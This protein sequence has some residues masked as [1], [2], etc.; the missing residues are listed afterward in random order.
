MAVCLSPE[1]I[2]TRSACGEA[3]WI[4]EKAVAKSEL[5]GSAVIYMAT[6]FFV[7]V[8]ADFRYALWA[9]LAGLVGP[10]GLAVRRPDARAT[11]APHPAY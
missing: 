3:T 2:R 1:A 8:A 4:R 5:A 6:F 11:L 7:G 10:V 9:V